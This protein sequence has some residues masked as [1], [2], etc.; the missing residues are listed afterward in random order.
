ML[1]TLT[2]ILAIA[3]QTWPQ[4]GGPT[5]DFHVPGVGLHW[6]GAAPARAWQRELG[7]GYSAIVGDARTL[8]AA[9]RRDQT[10]VIAALDAGTGRPRWE[11]TLDDVLLP[12]MFLEYGRG[13]N[14]TPV[15]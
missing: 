10:V 9:W 14:S 13:P 8:Y 3:G 6:T 12:N 5:R 11:Q 15:V 4:W 1:Q 2:L 7:E